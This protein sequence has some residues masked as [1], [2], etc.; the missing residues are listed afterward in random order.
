MFHAGFDIHI[1]VEDLVAEGD[2]VVDRWTAR[3]THKGEFFGLPATGKLVTI[4]GMDIARLVNGKVAEIW[5]LEDIMGLM[6]QLGAVP[7]I[8][9]GK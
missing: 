9:Q 8:A 5:H 3:M 4:T 6:Q 1:N 2:K 7:P